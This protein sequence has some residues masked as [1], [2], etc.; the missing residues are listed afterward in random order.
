MSSTLI[1]D[2][3]SLK[4]TTHYRID[5]TPLDFNFRTFGFK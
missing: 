5:E 2:F 4:L 1:S 3:I